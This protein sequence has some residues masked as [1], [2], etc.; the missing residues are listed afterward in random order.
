LSANDR[1]KDVDQDTAAADLFA[2]A[3]YWGGG[4]GAPPLA[5][6]RIPFR[7]WCHLGCSP[8]FATTA[9]YLISFFKN[10][11][12][13]TRTHCTPQGVPNVI[14]S[15]SAAIGDHAPQYFIWRISIALMIMQRLT[16]GIAY[17]MFFRLKANKQVLLHTKGARPLHAVARKALDIAPDRFQALLNVH[18]YAHM[19][20]QVGLLLLSMVSSTE[21]KVQTRSP[22]IVVRKFKH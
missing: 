3:T 21:H 20:E 14:M 13:T 1:S 11:E 22:V 18:W 12:T 9:C 19:G 15:I 8:L 16:D 5:Y 6:M 2:A 10:F 7:R 17:D 4:E